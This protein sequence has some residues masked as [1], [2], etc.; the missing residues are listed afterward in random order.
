MKKPLE[1]KTNKLENF[2][3][4]YTPIYGFLNLLYFIKQ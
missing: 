1:I 3:K 4:Y 2:K